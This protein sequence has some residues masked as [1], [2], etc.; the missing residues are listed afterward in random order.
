MCIW[1]FFLK[2]CHDCKNK[3]KHIYVCNLCHYDICIN[4]WDNLSNMCIKCY[5][6]FKK[7]T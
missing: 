2:K 7:R 6:F 5:D 4:C 1:D 3:N